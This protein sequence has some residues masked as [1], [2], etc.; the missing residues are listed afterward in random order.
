ML[1]RS[2]ATVGHYNYATTV[3]S[4]GVKVAGNDFAVKAD[5]VITIT[6]T[7]VSTNI[8]DTDTITVVASNSDA[9][10]PG[11]TV[12]YEAGTYTAGATGNVQT[13]KIS[14]FTN[15]STLTAPAGSNS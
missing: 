8:T 7:W 5:S 13:I 15:D 4:T 10:A 11:K 9:A 14:T 12:D 6:F 1:F 2:G 3:D